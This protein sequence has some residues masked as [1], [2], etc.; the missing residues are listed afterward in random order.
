MKIDSLRTQ[1]LVWLMVPLAAT[2]VLNAWS[3]YRSAAETGAVIQ[4]QLLTGSARMIGQQINFSDGAFVVQIPP[5]ALELFVAGDY[6]DRVYY[7][8][9]SPEG[10]LLSGYYEMDSPQEKPQAEQSIFFDTVMRDEPVHAVAY[11]QHVVGGPTGPVVIEVGQT[12]KARAALT[13]KIWIDEIREQLMMLAIVLVFLWFGLRRGLAPIIELRDRMLRRKPG[14][15]EMLDEQRVPTELRPLVAALNDYVERL[16]RHMSAHSRFIADASHQLRTPLSVLNTQ[17]TYALRNAD[18]RLKDEALHGMRKGVQGGIRLVNQL[19]AL[20]EAEVSVGLETQRKA[21]DISQVA[22]DVLEAHALA[23]EA[24]RIDLG[25][26]APRS[27]ITVHAADHLLHILI[28]NLLDNALRYTQPGGIVT[29]TVVALEDGAAQLR[30]EDNGPGIPESERDRVFERFYR[31]SGAQLDGCGL[32]LAI[33]REVVISCGAGID[34]SSTVQGRGLVVVVTFPPPP[35]EL[36][37]DS[38]AAVEP[39]LR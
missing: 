32:G 9:T 33:V 23:A 21:V 8:V 39:L 16:N 15:L 1:L 12:L 3:N 7:R 4:E 29:L 36:V 30:I 22:R 34:L 11:G 2:G 14:T 13:R 18:P 28:G 19:L 26:E 5:A 27:A 35:T 6:R 37:R 25:F 24:K 17:V 10:L 31:I 38:A 20:I